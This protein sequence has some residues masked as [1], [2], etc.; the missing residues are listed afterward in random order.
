MVNTEIRLTIFRNRCF[1]GTLL[2]FH[3]QTDV[4]NLISGSSAFSKTSLNISLATAEK[5]YTISENNSGADCGSDHEI[6][7]AKLRI[8]LKKV[9]KATRP[10]SSVQFSS[11]PQL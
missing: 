2:L 7:I 11:V 1:S 9:G 4:G 10:F 5:H 6:L 3:D 8:K